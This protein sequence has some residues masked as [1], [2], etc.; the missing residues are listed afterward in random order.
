MGCREGWFWIPG[1]VVWIVGP[2]GV[3]DGFFQMW[4]WDG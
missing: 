4:G 3:E 2:K 1:R